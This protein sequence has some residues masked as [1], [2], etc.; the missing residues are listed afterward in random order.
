MTIILACLNNSCDSNKAGGYVHRLLKN[1]KLGHVTFHGMEIVASV[2][3][4]VIVRIRPKVNVKDVQMVK[5][6]TY[7][8]NSKSAANN[9]KY[10][11]CLKCPPQVC[12]NMV[13]ANSELYPAQST[14][15]CMLMINH[16][17]LLL[18]F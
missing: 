5:I 10:N 13:H 11:I 6:K 8:H 17:I 3:S 4:G 12:Y 15:V 1:N 2:T 14:V 16:Y 7:F 9:I 18:N